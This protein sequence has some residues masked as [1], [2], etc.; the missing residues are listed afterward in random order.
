MISSQQLGERI[1]AE[2]KRQ[3]LTQ[4]QVASELQVS[5]TTFVA[6]EKGER[7]PSNAELLR[8]AE[9]LG[10]RLND[11]LRE[12]AVAAEISPRF[13]MGKTGPAS[14]VAAAVERLRR[15]ATRYVE[16]EHL[17]GLKR[18]RAPLEALHTYAT[19]DL[20]SAQQAAADG[21]EAALSVRALLG[22]GDEPIL[23]LDQRLESEAGLRIFYLDKLPSGISAFLIWTDAIGGCVAINR[24]HPFERQ[25][26]SL[27]HE[28]GHF[29]R[30]REAGDILTEGEPQGAH[31]VFPES[32]T[33][34]FLMPSS[35]VR[36]RF[37]EKCRAG[38][39]TPV[40]LHGL[41]QSYAVSFQAMAFRLEE[42]GLLPT[43]TYEKIRAS[44]VKPSDL[45]ADTPRR[46][47]PPSRD[48]GLPDRY[49]DLAVSAY[50]QAL[51]SESEFAA[52]LETDIAAARDIHS[53][54]ATLY[55][56]DGARL[57]VDL[58][59]ADLRAV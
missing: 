7:R 2:R 26:W 53:R 50:N 35:G 11:L 34:E 6:I 15:L 52:Y 25:R 22:M 31:E 58:T 36:K 14:Q 18:K 55:V 23:E 45:G 37:A 19:E 44:N 5:R 24:A 48:E 20:A 47:G 40:D 29:L 17:H 51:L 42:L 16:L 28:F 59:G 54:R 27:A 32:F 38:R 41:S 57:P 12:T 8:I 46:N 4:A 49:V 9:V 33:R 3:R 30:D 56:D 21:A 1:A 13:R 43:G 10:V 39:F